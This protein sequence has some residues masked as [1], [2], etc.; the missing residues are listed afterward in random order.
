M[1]HAHPCVGVGR[2]ATVTLKLIPQSVGQY[3]L[4]G[5]FT[6]RKKEK[7]CLQ[8]NTTKNQGLQHHQMTLPPHRS[9]G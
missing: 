2:Q 4:F 7:A 8:S 5:H 1:F 9:I 3:T 6:G